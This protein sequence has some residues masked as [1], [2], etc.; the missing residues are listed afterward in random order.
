[1]AELYIKDGIGIFDNKAVNADG[2]AAG[3]DLVFSIY[4]EHSAYTATLAE[5]MLLA[6]LWKW[7]RMERYII[8]HRPVIRRSVPD[9]SDM[10]KDQAQCH[11][12][13]M[14]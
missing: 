10:K 12:Q 5:R 7:Y 11:Y 8:R 3:D 4:G 1:M 9:H 13:Q 14:N 6:G 2:K